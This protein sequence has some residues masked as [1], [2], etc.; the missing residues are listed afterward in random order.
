M[1]VFEIIYRFKKGIVI[2]KKEKSM[3]VKN[4]KKTI[5]GIFCN[6]VYDK[7]SFFVSL[8]KKTW[9]CLHHLNVQPI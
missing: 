3:H 9:D 6:C 8:L 5:K 1:I 2:N 4:I 7:E